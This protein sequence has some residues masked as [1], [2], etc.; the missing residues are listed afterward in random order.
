MKTAKA[1]Q[2]PQFSHVCGAAAIQ[3]LALDPTG[4]TDIAL[5]TW[6]FQPSLLARSHLVQAEG[7]PDR[8]Y[9]GSLMASDLCLAEQRCTLLEVLGGVSGPWGISLTRRMVGV[10]L[11]RLIGLDEIPSALVAQAHDEGMKSILLQLAQRIPGAVC[12]EAAEPVVPFATAALA[13]RIFRQITSR[14]P[15]RPA[16]MPFVLDLRGVTEAAMTEAAR[17]VYRT[18]LPPLPAPVSARRPHPGPWRGGRTRIV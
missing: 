12:Y 2:M 14:S 6:R 3:A 5:L 15:H 7:G 16:R 4:P 9:L 17:A 10:M 1:A 18:R 8:S 13:H 11:L